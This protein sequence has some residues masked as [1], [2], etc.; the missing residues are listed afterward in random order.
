MCKV[1]NFAVVASDNTYCTHVRT[2]T[3]EALHQE[4]QIH[5][6]TIETVSTLHQKCNFTECLFPSTAY[7]AAYL[8]SQLCLYI[9]YDICAGSCDLAS[10]FHSSCS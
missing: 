6:I 8:V 2:V 7:S 3:E 9:T 10:C 5:N 4:T 1:T